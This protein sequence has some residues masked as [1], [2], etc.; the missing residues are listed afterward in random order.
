MLLAYGYTFVGKWS[1][2]AFIK[3]PSAAAAIYSR[4]EPARG[5]ESEYLFLGP[6]GPPRHEENSLLRPRGLYIELDVSLKG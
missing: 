2:R 5:L 3:D 1:L 6:V 4:L